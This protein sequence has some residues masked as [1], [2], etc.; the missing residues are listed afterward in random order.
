MEKST[1]EYKGVK[2]TCVNI[3]ANKFLDCEDMDSSVMFT[4]ADTRL[5]HA[6]EKDINNGDKEA[7]KI[8]E[9]VFFYVDED[10]MEWTEPKIVNNINHSIE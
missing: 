2:Y 4:I 10:M 3:P 1:I 5:W 7:E 8:D 9:G 6:L